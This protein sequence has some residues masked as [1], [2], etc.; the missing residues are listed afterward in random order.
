MVWAKMCYLCL[1][2][3]RQ[4]KSHSSEIH[5]FDFNNLQ[6]K[7]ARKKLEKLVGKNEFVLATF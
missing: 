3:F 5:N 6:E 7:L 4:G 2:Y 1:D